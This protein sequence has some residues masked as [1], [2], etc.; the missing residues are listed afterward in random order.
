MLRINKSCF[1]GVER[2]VESGEFGWHAGYIN[3]DQRVNDMGEKTFSQKQAY[4]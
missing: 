4:K 2:G 1:A 3:K